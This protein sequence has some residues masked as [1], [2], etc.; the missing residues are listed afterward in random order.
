MELSPAFAV[1][2]GNKY[3]VHQKWADENGRLWE[4]TTAG[5][6]TTEDEAKIAAEQINRLTGA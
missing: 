6:F 2:N 1:T 4:K 3:E 5:P